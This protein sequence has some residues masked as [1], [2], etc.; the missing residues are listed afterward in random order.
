VDRF[1]VEARLANGSTDLKVTLERGSRK[2]SFLNGIAFPRASDLLGRL[3]CVCISSLDLETVRGEPSERRLFLDLELSALST[4][5][6]QH[7]AQYRRSLEQRNALLKTAREHPVEAS[8][9]EVWEAALAEHGAILRTL[10]GEYVAQLRPIL[11]QFQSELGQCEGLEA[12]IVPADPAEEQEQF[13]RLLRESRPQEIAR[14]STSVGPHRDDL[15]LSLDGSPVR[16]FGSQGQQRSTAISLKLAAMK[17]IQ[18]RL[19]APPL[20]L[21]DDIFSDLD[22]RRRETLVEIVADHAGQTVLTC[23]E[24]S[25]TGPKILGQAKLFTVE[26]G[27]VRQE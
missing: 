22:S 19:G 12:K 9:F 5:Y 2:R 13:I 8:A 7:F 11:A 10:R 23:T 17:V 27:T 20:L 24:S 3:P 15:A 4:R 26:R 14:G 21:L 18:D 6:L 1:A 16:L 25:L